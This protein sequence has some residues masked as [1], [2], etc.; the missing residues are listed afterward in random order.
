MDERFVQVGGGRL[1]V[2]DSST[3]GAPVILVAGVGNTAAVWGDFFTHLSTSHRVVAVTRRGYGRSHVP[4]RGTTI[5]NLAGD[6]LGL[7]DALALDRAHF[8]GHSAAGSE[9]A[10]L[11][12]AAPTR[13]ESMVFLDA[14][15]DRRELLDLLA[16]DPTPA[17]IP[18]L[19]ARNSIDDLVEW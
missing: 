11:A 17:P 13:V 12:H 2:V 1:H 10:Y 8:V 7:L 6:L 9:L 4:N 19:T 15:Y 3:P 18:P 5:A 14:A 16:D